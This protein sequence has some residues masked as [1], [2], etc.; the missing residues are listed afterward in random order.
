MLLEVLST[1][2]VFNNWG[3]CFSLKGNPKRFN[4]KDFVTV[5]PRSTQTFRPMQV[6]LWHRSSS[7]LSKR[8]FLLVPSLEVGVAFKY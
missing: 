6:L 2:K 3:F 4:M 7:P 1:F 8:P 5:L